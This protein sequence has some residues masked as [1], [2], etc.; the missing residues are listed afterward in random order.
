MTR[1]A[2]LYLQAKTLWLFGIKLPVLAFIDSIRG[3]H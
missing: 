3:R 2:F 1:L